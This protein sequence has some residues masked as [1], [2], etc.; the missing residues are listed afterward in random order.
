MMPHTNE[1]CN[2]WRSNRQTHR[3]TTVTLRYMCRG[4]TMGVPY[5]TVYV[6]VT[7]FIHFIGKLEF[8]LLVSELMICESHTWW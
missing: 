2:S 7:R 6:K 8:V 4:L 3:T 1:V 5:F